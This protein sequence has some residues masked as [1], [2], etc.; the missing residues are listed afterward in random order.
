MKKSRP[1]ASSSPQSDAAGPTRRVRLGGRASE[2]KRDWL[3]CQ[4]EGTWLATIV[5]TGRDHRVQGDVT[6]VCKR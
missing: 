5:G 4:G 6:I 2:H 1:S 3:S